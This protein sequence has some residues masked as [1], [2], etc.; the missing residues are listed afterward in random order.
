M[1]LR[2]IHALVFVALAG[3][4]CTRTGGEPS[5]TLPAAL[6]SVRAGD[7]IALRIGETASLWNGARIRVDDVLSD[8]RCPRGAQCVWAGDVRVALTV[9]AAGAASRVD[10]IGLNLEPRAAAAGTASVRLV[11]MEPPPEQSGAPP[12]SRY[13]ASFLISAPAK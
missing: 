7:T 2:P 4:G 11:G 8:S 5:P 6:A 12:R 10:T 9:T 3:A 1:I 13:V